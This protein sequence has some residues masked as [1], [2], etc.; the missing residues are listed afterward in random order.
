MCA[1][2][3]RLT[4]RAASNL[5]S[6]GPWAGHHHRRLMPCLLACPCSP[7]RH[8]TM[9]CAHARDTPAARPSD[10][11]PFHGGN[12]SSAH[13]SNSH[14]P[15]GANPPEQLLARHG[16]APRCAAGA[17]LPPDSRPSPEWR[18]REPP[19]R[20]AST[21]PRCESRNPPADAGR[22]N[23]RPPWRL[24]PLLVLAAQCVR[25]GD[26]ARSI[27]PL[28]QPPRMPKRWTPDTSPPTV[29]TTQ[30]WMI[31]RPTTKPRHR[32]GRPIWVQK[33]MC[34]PASTS[35]PFRPRMAAR[36]F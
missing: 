29:G 12:R 6:M 5:P 34:S 23:S 20:R 4:P 16:V 19:D 36:R 15:D 24:H 14:A 1:P 32:L 25:C 26:G 35:K 2:A 3:V 17:S 10:E 33:L 28:P 18:E 30:S 11:A 22:C 13:R 8:Q 9:D 31:S 21:V 27:G 7:A